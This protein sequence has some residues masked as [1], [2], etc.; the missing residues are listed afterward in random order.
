ARASLDERAVGGLVSGPDGVLVTTESG[1]VL[2]WR[3]PAVPR[4]LGSVGGTPKRGGALVDNRTLLAVVDGKMLIAFDLPTGT[5][6]VRAHSAA[7]GSSLDGPVAVAPGGLAVV[8]TYG[9]VLL[10]V[11]ASGGEKLHAIIDKQAQSGPADAG[12]FASPD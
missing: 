5:S 3:P 10:G 2:S 1:V 6:H 7:V 8:A 12:F 4:K 9:G 11:D